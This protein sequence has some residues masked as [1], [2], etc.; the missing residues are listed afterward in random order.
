[1]TI[2]CPSFHSIFLANRIHA[3][4]LHALLDPRNSPSFRTRYRDIAT[5]SLSVVRNAS[6]ITGSAKAKFLVSRLM[7]LVQLR[8]IGS[9]RGAKPIVHS[10]DYSINLE[11]LYVSER[12]KIT[13]CPANLMSSLSTFALLWIEHCTVLNLETSELH[14]REFRL[15]LPTL[16]YNPEPSGSAS[17]TRI[18]SFMDFRNR[19]MPAIVPP[20]PRE[21]H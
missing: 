15:L 13:C 14:C 12:Q 8:Q 9:E 10:L 17:A 1:V 5:A 4:R 2:T 7:P 21:K 3:T 18:S 6:S 16:L 11:K 19:P 20:V